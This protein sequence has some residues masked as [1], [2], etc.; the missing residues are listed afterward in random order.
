MV[1]LRVLG[2]LPITV[3]YDAYDDLVITH[4]AGRPCK[5]SPEWLFKRLEKTGEI[6][7]IWKRFLAGVEDLKWD[8]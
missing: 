7:T 2:G 3:T 4:I 8:R 5:K 1:E 6:R